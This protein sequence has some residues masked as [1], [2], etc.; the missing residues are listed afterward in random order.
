MDKLLRDKIITLIREAKGDFDHEDFIREMIETLL[1]LIQH[2]VSR[3]DIKILHTTLKEMRYAFKLFGPYNP[4]RKVSVFGSARTDPSDPAYAC[5]ALFARKMVSAGFMVITGAGDG[6]MRA[7][8]EGAGRSQSFGMNI[9]LPFEQETNEFIENDPKL[10]TFK[11]FFIRKLFFVKEANAIA[12]FPGGFGTHDE[13]FEVLTLLQTGKSNP[14]PVV[15]IDPP[16]GTYW[17]TWRTY[18]EDQFLSRG[19]ISPEDIHLFKVTDRVEDAVDEITRFYQ[20]YRSIRF[21]R[22]RMVIRLHHPVQKEMLDDLND[23]FSDIVVG[24]RI[25]ESDPLPEAENEPETHAEGRIVF[26]FNRRNFGRL[27]QMI[28]RIN[29]YPKASGAA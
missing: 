4:M 12:L 5:S 26:H 27:R 9:L 10:I 29:L 13:G 19:L 25:V 24:G 17:K 7:A 2:P 14:M 15:M 22:D 23:T 11:Y 3:G 21:V 18:I 28:D 6:I 16:G 1:R 20:N 8:Q